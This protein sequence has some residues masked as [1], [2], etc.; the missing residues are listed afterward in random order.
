MKEKKVKGKKN[1]R[2][3]KRKNDRKK[4]K[5]KKGGGTFPLATKG[6]RRPKAGEIKQQVA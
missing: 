3:K 2:I 6:A 5:E 1:E 4:I